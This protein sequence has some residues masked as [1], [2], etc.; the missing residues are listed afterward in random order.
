MSSVLF[1]S[2]ICIMHVTE[3]TSMK[4]RIHVCIHDYFTM[5]LITSGMNVIV[6]RVLN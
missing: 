3:W 4:N 2:Y 5:Q 6:I 1:S